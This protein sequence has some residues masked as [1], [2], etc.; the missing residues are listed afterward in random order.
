MFLRLLIAVVLLLQ[1]V[2]P[3]KALAQIRSLEG[4]YRNPALGCSIRIPRGLKGV[5]GDQAGPER[6]V[7]ISLPSGASIWVFGELN[8]QEWATPEEGIRWWLAHT[9]CKPDRQAVKPTRLGKITG[10]KGTVSC[11]DREQESVLAFRPQGGPIYWLQLETTRG[12]ES[13][14][15]AILEKLA[16]SFRLIPWG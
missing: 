8:S 9:D 10:T 4:T 13:E 1:T 5:T 11:G 6:G 12:H 16:S 3:D 2:Y 14:D 15:D 7:K